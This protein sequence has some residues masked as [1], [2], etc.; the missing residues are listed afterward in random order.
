MESS[1][2]NSDMTGFHASLHNQLAPLAS[3]PPAS[4]LHSESPNGLHT[5]PPIQTQNNIAKYYGH[6]SSAIHPPQN[7]YTPSDTS[8][9]VHNQGYG[10][11]NLASQQAFRSNLTNGSY[12]PST[13]ASQAMSAPGTT[14]PSS[15][16]NLNALSPL[17][18]RLPDLRPMPQSSFGQPPS[19]QLSQHA[20]PSSTQGYLPN[21]EPQPTHV[22]GSQGRRGIL[23]SAPGRAAVAGSASSKG[24][25]PSKDAD[26]KFPCPFCTKTY[27]H[28]KHLKRH[29]L[30][31]KCPLFHYHHLSKIR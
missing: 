13:F 29:L 22:V 23:P 15:S 16:A 6:A 28:A 21:P 14:A 26:G 12:L 2:F 19:S 9:A 10:L 24:A 5:L 27:L 20:V 30:R 4:Y 11:P 31:R 8:S 25:I 1:T 3:L 7:S 18:N 17:S